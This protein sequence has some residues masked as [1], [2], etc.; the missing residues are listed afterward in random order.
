MRSRLFLMAL[1]SGLLIPSKPLLIRFLSYLCHETHF[2]Y[3]EVISNHFRF[4]HSV[5]N[6]NVQ[7]HA[8]ISLEYIWA[9]KWWPHCVFSFFL[10]VTEVN[11]SLAESYFI[12]NDAPK[13][14][15][16][17]QMLLAKAL[18]NNKYILDEKLKLTLWRIPQGK[19]LPSHNLIKLPPYRKFKGCWI[20][21]SKS[22][23]PQATC[24]MGH[25][26]IMY[27]LLLLSRNPPMRSML[28]Y[29]LC[30]RWKCHCNWGLISV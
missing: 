19:H 4:C 12:T 18:I 11:V 6:H 7:R 28:C 5:D 2:L 23:Y 16:E 13:R 30:R 8:P 9:T 29:A 1:K 26:K 15:L 14:Q 3:P 17:F 22:Q 21:K 10:A 20:I 25:R 27:V 24:G